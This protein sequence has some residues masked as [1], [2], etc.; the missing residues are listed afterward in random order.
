MYFFFAM[1]GIF[2]LD[3]EVWLTIIGLI[4]IKDL[5]LTMITQALKTTDQIL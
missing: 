5:K 1:T 2:R 3:I 4:Y